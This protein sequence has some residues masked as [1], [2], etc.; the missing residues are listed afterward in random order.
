[1]T[2]LTIPFRDDLLL[3]VDN[4]AKDEATSREELINSVIEAYVRK[5]E[6]EG[7]CAY[8][9][10]WAEKAQFTEEDLANEIGLYREEKSRS[11]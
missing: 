5:K 1:M 8:W 7:T 10:G 9:N 2:T 4:F 6:F 3:K 11:I